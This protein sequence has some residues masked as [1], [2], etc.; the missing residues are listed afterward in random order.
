MKEEQL[1]VETLHRLA[2]RGDELIFG[3]SEIL[4]M[5]LE[6]LVDDL[7]EGL[8]Q[9]DRAFMLEAGTELR[10]RLKPKR[11]AHSISVARTCKRYATIYGVDLSM[12]TRAG[13]IHDWDKCY[14]GQEVFDR[15]REMGVELPEGYEHME[16]LFHSLTGAKALEQRFPGL[17][18][19]ILQ[20]VARHTSGA[21]DMAPLDIIVYVADM[22]EPTRAYA[23]LDDLR[24]L[25]GEVDLETL[26]ARCFEVTV[27]FL[28]SKRR[29]FHPETANIWNAW[30]GE[31]AFSRMARREAA[32]AS[33]E[34]N[35]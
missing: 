11:F 3:T 10:Q 32:E 4:N 14:H 19:Q 18:P 16:A 1:D 22:I 25:V 34:R 13:L 8:S 17:E 5:P 6:V 21:V 29:Y 24:G 7:A 20:A 28:V 2:A 30:V 35:G 15:C 33:G 23:S 31:S 27:T 12:A 9:A 26:F